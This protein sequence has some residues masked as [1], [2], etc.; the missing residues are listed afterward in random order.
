[1]PARDMLAL[2]SIWIG[3]AC[4]Q[5]KRDDVALQF[6]RLANAI[7]PDSASIQGHIGV[8]LEAIGQRNHALKWFRMS[9]NGRVMQG[10]DLLHA[11]HG[12]QRNLEKELASKAF[13][14]AATLEPDNIRILKEAGANYLTNHRISDANRLF[15]Q[16][17]ALAPDNPEIERLA[18]ATRSSLDPN[19]QKLDFVIIGTTGTCNASC[20]HCPTGKAATA[21]VPRKPMDMELFRHLIDQLAAS[22]I[23]ITG[24]IAFGLFGDGLVDPFVVE[25]AAYVHQMLPDVAISV[26]TNGAAYDPKRHA[27]LK[28]YI[29]LITLH[30]E[31]IDPK[32]YDHLMA[33]LRAERV[34]AKFPGLLRD[35]PN[36]VRVSVPVS[37]ANHDEMEAMFS[38]FKAMGAENVAFHPLSSRCSRDQ[39]LFDS[40]SFDPQI[41]RCEGGIFNNLIIDSDGAVVACCNDFEREVPVGKLRDQSLADLLADPR[42]QKMIR[43]LE[44]GQHE[45]ISTCARCRA[46]I[47]LPTAEIALT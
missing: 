12:L 32:V 2:P 27:K 11:A 18:K 16:A 10:K 8:S 31:S 39:S 34:H 23:S 6:F 35:F 42:R 21:H 38:H 3:H 7:A 30:C 5:N 41:I 19:V 40:L 43:L 44:E 29:S 9:V 14:R 45:N 47:R 13:D 37:R 20:I 24:Q 1:M 25:R 28:K 36:M 4:R 22:Q 17:L 15:E 26:N 46:D 33:P